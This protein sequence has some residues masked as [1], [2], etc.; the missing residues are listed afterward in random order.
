[1]GRSSRTVAVVA[2]CLALLT[3]GFVA[4]ATPVPAAQWA[5]VVCV[6]QNAFATTTQAAAPPDSFKTVEDVLKQS[7]DL[8]AAK[9]KVVA[10]FDTAITAA[11]TLVSAVKTAGVPDIRNGDK[12]ERAVLAAAMKYQTVLDKDKKRADALDTTDEAAFRDTRHKIIDSFSPLHD[13]NL[14]TEKTVA[15]LDKGHAVSPTLH[16]C[17]LNGG[18][19]GSNAPPPGTPPPPVPPGQTDGPGGGAPSTVPLPSARAAGLSTKKV[20]ASKWVETVCAAEKKAHDV[21]ASKIKPAETAAQAGDLAGAKTAFVGFIDALPGQ[22]KTLLSS[23]KKAGVPKVTNGQ[24]IA[25]TY[26]VTI[27]AVMNALPAIKTEAEAVPTSDPDALRTAV[28]AVTMRFLGVAGPADYQVLA[29][30]TSARVAGALHNCGGVY[31][32]G[33]VLPGANEFGPP[34]NAPPPPSE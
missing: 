2:A 4:D 33:S 16:D 17:P 25:L 27:Q 1:M 13:I 32:A 26:V 8:A 11:T 20:S 9:S 18:R 24:H 12:I 31:A 3:F 22:T 14:E 28:R 7:T 15:T 21:A 5:A 10:F 30:D 29:L 34:P 19:G 6:A 23:L